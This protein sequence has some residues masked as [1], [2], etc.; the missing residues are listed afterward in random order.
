M[1]SVL[2]IACVAACCRVPI[3]P[4]IATKL[5]KPISI[6]TFWKDTGREIL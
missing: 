1:K 5:R 3:N 6:K 2:I 4:V